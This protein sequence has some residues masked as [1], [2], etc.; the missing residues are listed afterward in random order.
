MKKI[1]VIDD[2]KSIREIV[3]RFL[4]S[5]GYEVLFAT[6]GLEGMERA[7]GF[8]P[9]LI[10]LDIDMPKMNGISLCSILKSEEKTRHIPVLFLTA[11]D[12]IETAEEAIKEGGEG[13]LTKPFEFKRFKVKLEALLER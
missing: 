3:G 2:D 12:R 5:L 4:K 1:L 13:Y 7:R 10:V 11:K 8:L 6:D 9:D